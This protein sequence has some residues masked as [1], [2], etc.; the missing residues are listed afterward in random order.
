MW[1]DHSGPHRIP[2]VNNSGYTLTTGHQTKLRAD[3]GPLGVDPP[4][5]DSQSSDCHPDGEGSAR[6]SAANGGR[7]GETA[8]F[9]V[10]RGRFTEEALVFAGELTRALLA[11]FESGPCGVQSLDEHPLPRAHQSKLFLIPQ[12]A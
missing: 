4:R 6:Y 1:V 5:E 10:A 11:H 9:D 2:T 7:A 8:G 3:N 12:W